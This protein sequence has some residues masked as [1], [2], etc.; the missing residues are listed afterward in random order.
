MNEDL[1][2][3]SSEQFKTLEVEYVILLN[4]EALKKV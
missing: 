4:E 1:S 3:M 2:V